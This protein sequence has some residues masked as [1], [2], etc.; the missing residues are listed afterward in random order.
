MKKENG[1]ERKIV[2]FATTLAML[3]I[4]F[5]TVILWV[6]MY[7]GRER[8]ETFTVGESQEELDQMDCRVEIYP[9]GGSTDN[10]VKRVEETKEN[11]EIEE[12]EYIGT[13][14]EIKVSNYTTDKLTNWEARVAMP[15]DG[16]INNAWCGTMEIHQT[17][18]GEQKIQTLDLRNYKAEDIELNYDIKESD[19][20]IPMTGDD[21]FRY[22]PSEVDQENFVAA[23]S[24]KDDVINAKA[25][26]FIVYFSGIDTDE[27]VTFPEIILTYHLEKTLAKLIS[28][29][30]L[31]VLAVIWLVSLIVVIMGDLRVRSLLKRQAKDEEI[32]E[33]S[34]S[35]FMEFIDAKDTNT[36]GHSRRVGQ[37]AAKLAKKLGMDENACNEIYYIALMHDCG[38]IGIPESILKKPGKLTDEE[39]DVIK[40]HTTLGGEMLKNFN[41]LKHI[42][43][44]A[45]YHHERYDGKG[46]PAGL[47]GEEIPMI[48]RIICVAD[49][50][51][52]MNSA[53]CYRSKLT[54]D[55]IIEELRNNRGTQ[56]D[57]DVVDCMLELLESHEIEC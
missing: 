31:V 17:V 47:A 36:N 22:I 54:R 4:G 55:T 32:I 6:S 20:L 10:W 9:R 26:G 45:L 14:Y 48:G 13:I 39:Y 46:Y 42:R 27:A 52:A 23:S 50:F 34:I 15:R 3:A 56:F 41:S 49:S 2:I 38:K 19:L 57:P 53:R 33:Q 1:I 24:P 18:N 44:G 5:F 25:A 29:R 11:G 35:T 21:F 30:V 12:T 43:E 51:D 28:F 16:F 8:V 40:S 7:N 37:Y